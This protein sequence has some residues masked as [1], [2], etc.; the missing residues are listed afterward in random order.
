MNKPDFDPAKLRIPPD[1]VDDWRK[2]AKNGKA[3]PTHPPRKGKFLRGPVPVAWLRRAAEL[4][5][6]ALAVGLALWF[7]RGCRKRWTVQLT[8]RTLQHFAV[9]RK[10][11]YLGLDNLE[12]AGLVR[13]QRQVGKCPVVTICLPSK[14]KKPPAD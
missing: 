8:R 1:T 12:A 3:P 13:V 9:N 5:G 14:A 11:G 2:N 7:L 4:P 10:P 6:K